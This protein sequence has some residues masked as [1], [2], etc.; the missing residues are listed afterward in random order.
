MTALLRE[1]A[2]SLLP[3]LIAAA[4][5]FM[6]WWKGRRSGRAAEIA[7]Q[8]DGARTARRKAIKDLPPG[9]EKDRAVQEA[10]QK[11]AERLRGR[12]QK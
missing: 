3:W 10:L 12:R 4:A 1:W 6:A 2:P 5:L 11:T 8:E 9:P 7:G